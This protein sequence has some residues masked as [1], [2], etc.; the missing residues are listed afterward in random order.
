MY[1]FILSMLTHTDIIQCSS[2]C[3]YLHSVEYIGLVD[4]ESESNTSP[5]NSINNN[6][7]LRQSKWTVSIKNLRFSWTA[8]DTSIIRPNRIEW[9]STSGLR[10]MGSVDF[11]P[12]SSSSS[13]ATE[14]TICFKFITPRVVSSL[15][16][17]SVK[18][19]QYTEDVLLG[20]ML[21]DFRDAIVDEMEEDQ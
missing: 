5:N 13:T 6:I 12:Q 15:F 21:S 7:P 4:E 3:K 11:T 8:S 14:M 20:N 18:I 9:Q 1:T 10:N 16:R 19:R 2:W 17:R